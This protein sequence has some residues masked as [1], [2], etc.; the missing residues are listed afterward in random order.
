M[1]GTLLCENGKLAIYT[2]SD[3]APFSDPAG[4]LSRV[5]FHS[6]LNYPAILYEVSGTLGL[7]ARGANSAGTQSFNL[8]AHG[9]SGS[10]L[11]IGYAT[12]GGQRIHLCGSVPVQFTSRGW[13][14]W[15]ALGADGSNVKIVDQWFAQSNAAFGGVSIPWKVYVLAT[16]FDADP[17]LNSEALHVT[18]TEFRAGGGKFDA[19]NRYLRNGNTLQTFPLVRGGR[20]I[21]TGMARPSNFN[22]V[23]I[24]YSLAGY[25]VATSYT[26]SPSPGVNIPVTGPGF[27]ASYS[28]VTT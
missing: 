3:D 15:I 27:A 5:L 26:F 1:A 13:G 4:N 14:R 20:T 21:L 11:V 19:R 18:P 7:P 17:D 22:I 2:G 6:D 28:L 24:T 12:L 10:P 25:A 9:R 23:T 8:F 16:N